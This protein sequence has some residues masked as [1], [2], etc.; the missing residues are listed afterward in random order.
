M[1]TSFG[2]NDGEARNA[3]DFPYAGSVVLRSWN[4]QALFARCPTRRRQKW[5]H[6]ARLMKP[7]DALGVQETHSTVG[8]QAAARP[9]SGTRHWFSHESRA[10]GGIGLIV[11][12]SFLSQF[13]PTGP[14]NWIEVVP[15]RA[16]ILQLD[17]PGGSLDL[18]TVYLYTGAAR[19]QRREV[20]HKLRRALRPQSRALTVL[21][22][23]WN[24]VKDPQ[25]RINLR[26]AEWSHTQDEEEHQEWA[27]GLF[28][29]MGLREVPQPDLTNRT[30]IG[31][32]RIDRAYQNSHLAEQ[33]FSEWSTTAL[34]WQDRLSTHR[35][36]EL[37]RRMPGCK[38]SKPP[39][40]T[41]P[42]RSPT[43]ARDVVLRWQWLQHKDLGEDS[44][45][46]RLVL[47]K[48]AM[49]QISEEYERRADFKPEQASTARDKL[50]AAIRALRAVTGGRQAALR[51][52]MEELPELTT[53]RGL[54]PGWG[55]REKWCSTLR[56][57]SAS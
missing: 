16:A 13:D 56:T 3:K 33:Q 28:S 6:C 40:S 55:T 43:W 11:K 35:P 38:R 22:G 14:D 1:Q 36:I 18:V 46:R 7:A 2:R 9:I 41:R 8:Y 23:D 45:H 52:A 17:G 25:D 31:A 39:V 34:G 51:K 42:C 21:I 54:R 53:S 10:R 37:A 4:A 30:T 27:E 19:P 32:A 29:P 48:R 57:R 20:M 26:D 12:T 15:G 47:L 50:G 24:F 44:S 5:A 49:V